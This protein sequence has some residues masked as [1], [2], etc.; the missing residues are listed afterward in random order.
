MSSMRRTPHSA[1]SNTCRR[2]SSSRALD[3]PS[4]LAHSANVSSCGAY[5]QAVRARDV[6][7]HLFY[8]PVKGTAVAETRFRGDQAAMNTTGTRLHVSECDTP[9]ASVT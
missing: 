6:P 3:S 5:G 8:V 4:M 9:P 7:C 2:R 1:A